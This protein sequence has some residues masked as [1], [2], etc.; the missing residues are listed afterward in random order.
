MKYKKLLFDIPVDWDIAK[1]FV[2]IKGG[3]VIIDHPVDH[4]I[5]ERCTSDLLDGDDYSIE[6]LGADSWETKACINAGR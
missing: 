5:F 2:S 1:C 4:M 3:K 6:K